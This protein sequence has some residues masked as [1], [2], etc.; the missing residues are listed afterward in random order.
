LDSVR[1][2]GKIGCYAFVEEKEAQRSSINRLKGTM[3]VKSIESVTKNVFK[4]FLIDK[5]IPDIKAK[6]PV[7]PAK[8][9]IQL[10]NAKP[11]CNET[12]PDIVDAGTEGGWDIRLLFQPAKSPDFNVLDLGFFTAIQ[13]LQ[14]KETVRNPAELVQSVNAAFEKLPMI[15]LE[16]TFFTLQTVWGKCIK[17]CGGNQFKP[18]HIGKAKLRR[19]KI[20]PENLFCDEEIYNR[21][22]EVLS[23]MKEDKLFQE[24]KKASR[25]Q[26]KKK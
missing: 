24:K 8:V 4:S 14:Y 9:F 3:E 1:F 19:K 26:Q 18:P 20:L 6:W 7:K 11:H 2:D 15:T 22:I 21:G 23:M 10:D 16:N 13:S 12:D 5:V 25:K 17:H